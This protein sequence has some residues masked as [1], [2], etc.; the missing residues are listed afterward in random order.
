MKMLLTVIA[1]LLSVSVQAANVA[2][3][4]VCWDEEDCATKILSISEQVSID[5]EDDCSVDGRSCHEFLIQSVE[6]CK[7]SNDFSQD[8]CQRW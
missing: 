4:A 1:F 6:D 5:D 8:E 3:N 2:P 7:E